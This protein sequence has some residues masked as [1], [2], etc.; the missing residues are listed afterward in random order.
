MYMT[1]EISKEYACNT[2]TE[3]DVYMYTYSHVLRYTC[4]YNN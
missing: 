3:L 2:Q 1:I 4:K